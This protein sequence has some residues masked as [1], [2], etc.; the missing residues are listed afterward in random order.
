MADGRE[1][2]REGE[3]GRRNELVGRTRRRNA[4]ETNGAVTSEKNLKS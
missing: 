1:N 4:L 2:R 3:R